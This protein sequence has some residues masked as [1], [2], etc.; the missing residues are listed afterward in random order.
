[1]P[2][3]YA[4]LD[5]LGRG[6]MGRVV[7]AYDRKL[8]REVALKT[9]AVG[10]M[11][12]A[13]QRALVDEARAMARIRSPYVVA[14]FDVVLGPQADVVIVMEFMRGGTLE[15]WL[16]QERTPEQVLRVFVDAGRGLAAAH[17]ADVLH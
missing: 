9:L 4:L 2:P 8:A 5:E 14:V 3:R 16:Q 6:A 12:H 17:R 1:M 10:S 15:R 7:R 13:R 11:E